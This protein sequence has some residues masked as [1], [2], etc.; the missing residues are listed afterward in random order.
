[1]LGVQKDRQRSNLGVYWTKFHVVKVSYVVDM[2][3][4]R[5]IFNP[6]ELRMTTMWHV[7]QAMPLLRRRLW[8]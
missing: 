6:R 5:M 7:P 1:M 8:Y 3:D 2:L 4:L